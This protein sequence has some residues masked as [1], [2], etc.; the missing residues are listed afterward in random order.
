MDIE[1]TLH[2]DGEPRSLSVDTRTTVLDALREQLGVTVPKKGCDHGQC[3]SFTVLLDGRRANSCLALAVAHEGAEITTREGHLIDPEEQ[4]KKAID[5][6]TATGRE[7][8]S[9]CSMIHLHRS[10]LFLWIM[11]E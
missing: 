7:L 5:A 3:G 1:I 11:W 8:S 9:W 4:A 2:V 6:F 10:K